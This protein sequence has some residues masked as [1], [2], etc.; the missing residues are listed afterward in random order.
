MYTH[1][2]VV[3]ELFVENISFWQ[4]FVLTNITCFFFQQRNDFRDFL[5]MKWFSWIFL[6][7]EMIFRGFFLTTK[8]FSTRPCLR[9]YLSPVMNAIDMLLLYRVKEWRGSKTL[10]PWQNYTCKRRVL[11]LTPSSFK[12]MRL[13]NCRGFINPQI[14]LPT[15]I[16]TLRY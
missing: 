7:N 12:N 4:K 9:I 1:N 16:S 11:L 13:I 14:F 15:K 2:S 8:W 5:T 3:L 6:N 10:I